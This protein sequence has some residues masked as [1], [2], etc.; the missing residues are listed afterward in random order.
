MGSQLILFLGK[1]IRKKV[2][3]NYVSSLNSFQIFKIY[4]KFT[5]LY[6]FNSCKFSLIYKLL[7]VNIQ[8]DSRNF[9]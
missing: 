1:D 8:V 5:I 4:V 6:V 2:E 3:N 7:S 9:H